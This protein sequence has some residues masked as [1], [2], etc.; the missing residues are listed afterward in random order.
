MGVATWDLPFEHDFSKWTSF[1]VIL[2]V[3]YEFARHWSVDGSFVVGAPEH[4][5]AG[6]TGRVNSVTLLLTVTALAY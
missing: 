3:G 6:I 1:G 2:G 4:T 5:E